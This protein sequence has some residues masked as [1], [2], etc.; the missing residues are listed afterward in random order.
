[1]SDGDGA[2]AEDVDLARLSDL[3][4]PMAVRTA[5]TLRLGDHMAEGRRTPE[6]L[7]EA[8]GA[9]PDALGRVLEHLVQV[10]LA[11]RDGQGRYDL[12]GEGERLRSEHPRSVRAF[13]SVEHPVTRADLAFVHLPRSVRTGSASFPEQYG[14]GFWE[15]LA[16]A[17][18]RSAVF[19]AQ[20]SSDVSTVAPD[21][22]AACA[23]G[24][25]GSL[26]DVGGGDGTLLIELLRAHPGLRGA[27]VDLAPA[28]ERARA[29][30]AEAG[31]TDRAT[32]LA[33]DFFGEL[34]VGYGGYLLCAVVHDW[35]RSSAVAILRR[36]AE[37]AGPSGR[38]FIAERT[39]EDGESPDTWMNLRML[40]YFGGK[41]RGVTE[42]V[43]LAGEAG[44]DLVAAHPAGRMSVIELRPR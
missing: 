12:V 14:R 19:D 17:P 43:E 32:G 13:L 3:I 22:A 34:P 15:D 6:E 4:T 26:A 38:V 11:E 31:L 18:E 27:V 42:L 16:A 21:I 39:G 7:A 20:M 44:L 24:R 8:A 10:G 36:C 30:L 29:R 33:G 5:A 9:D 40:V 1:M 37:A 28:A 23:W 41:D 35:D 25:L 2:R